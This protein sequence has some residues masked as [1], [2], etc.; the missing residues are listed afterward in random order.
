MKLF[1]HA[2]NDI[3]TYD[4]TLVYGLIF[5]I[6]VDLPSHNHHCKVQID[7]F[8]EIRRVFAKNVSSVKSS[9]AV[10]FF[11]FIF[12]IVPGLSRMT[13]NIDFRGT[14]R[15]VS[16][17]ATCFTVPV[18]PSISCIQENPGKGTASGCMKYRDWV[19]YFIC[20]YCDSNP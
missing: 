20:L 15:K 4:I 9:R 16:H 17:T 12:S 8:S 14:Y 18:S 13:F 11:F 7:K 1:W 19:K 2:L 3:V 6:Q 10:F 5:L